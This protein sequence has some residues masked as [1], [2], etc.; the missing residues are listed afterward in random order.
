MNNTSNKLTRQSTQIILIKDRL[1]H[2]ALL[3]TR[4]L[5]TSLYN[6]MK[7]RFGIFSSCNHRSTDEFQSKTNDKY[8]EFTARSSTAI[9]RFDHGKTS[10]I[11]VQV[12]RFLDIRMC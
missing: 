6:D 1:H 5:P 4:S 12:G 7:N 11:A 3:R 9:V 8:S 10:E 2:A